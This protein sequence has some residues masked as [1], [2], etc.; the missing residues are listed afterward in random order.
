MYPCWFVLENIFIKKLTI[1]WSMRT[2]LQ[3]ILVHISWKNVTMFKSVTI[4][5]FLKLHFCK[6]RKGDVTWE[7][8][9]NNNRIS[10]NVGIIEGAGMFEHGPTEKK[11][12]PMLSTE[13][14]VL[15]YLQDMF[16]TCVMCNCLWDWEGPCLVHSLNKKDVIFYFN[17]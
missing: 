4:E 10:L 14:P 8:L 11:D 3:T 6:N 1:S 16:H 9:F 2:F 5:P 7:L 12:R 17:P 15:L 13:P